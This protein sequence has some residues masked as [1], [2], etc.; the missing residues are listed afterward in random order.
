MLFR[1]HEETPCV[2]VRIIAVEADTEEEAIAKVQDGD[3][4]VEVR[5]V[6][7]EQHDYEAAEYYAFADEMTQNT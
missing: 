3:F 2:E 4:D 7:L 6:V 1:I 5:R